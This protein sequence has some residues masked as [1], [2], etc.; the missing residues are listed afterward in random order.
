MKEYLESLTSFLPEQF[1]FM[2]PITLPTKLL[3]Q[4]FKPLIEVT[5][6]KRT[7]PDIAPIVPP[8]METLPTEEQYTAYT[9]RV[10]RFIGDLLGISPAKTDFFVREQF[11]VVGA[12]SMG[13]LPKFP[14]WRQEE[15]FKVAGRTVSRFYDNYDIIETQYKR[16]QNPN[17]T[18]S[19][20]EEINITRLRSLYTKV[21]NLLGMQ[22]DLFGEKIPLS[23][24][25]RQATFDLLVSLDE[26]TLSDYTDETKIT[27]IQNKLSDLQAYIRVINQDVFS[28]QSVLREAKRK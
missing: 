9:T 5:L 13:D 3:P 25:T 23:E 17:N 12:I 22:R 7:F 19:T 24:E 10:A 1:D 14:L 16:T 18:Y 27:E 11:G 15:E 26:V 21:N 6:N 4:L 20:Q 2:N 8:Y 28:K